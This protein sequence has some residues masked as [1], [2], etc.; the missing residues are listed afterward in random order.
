MSNLGRAAQA[1]RYYHHVVNGGKLTP[2]NVARMVETIEKL[3]RDLEDAR[4]PQ[5]THRHVKRGSEYRYIGSARIQTD[6]PLNDMDRVEI[7]R[8][9]GEDD[10]WARRAVEF[11]D[12]RFEPV[13][14]TD[15]R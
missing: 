5:P 3:E 4:N 11:H 6:V 10:L 9:V 7:Y 12:G 15:E 2:D 14:S 8:G 13:E 1:R